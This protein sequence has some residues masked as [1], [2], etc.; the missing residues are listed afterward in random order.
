MHEM[1]LIDDWGDTAQTNMW[2]AYMSG[3]TNVP[4]NCNK[5]ECRI[6]CYFSAFGFLL[7]TRSILARCRRMHRAIIPSTRTSSCVGRVCTLALWSATRHQV[8]FT[9]RS[10]C[11]CKRDWTRAIIAL[12]LTVATVMIMTIRRHYPMMFHFMKTE[13]N[14]KRTYLFEREKW[15]KDECYC[16]RYTFL[17]LVVRNCR[18]RRYCW[19]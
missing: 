14:K 6:R 1:D 2:S 7:L 8:R 5:P 18:R 12:V 19:H 17:R 11:T 3:I 4:A 10:N 15:R 9:R 16:R 13:K